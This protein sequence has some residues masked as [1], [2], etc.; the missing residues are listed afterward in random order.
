MLDKAH[1]N[2]QMDESDAY[3]A[4]RTER[5]RLGAL[6]VWCALLVPWFPFALLSG[7]AFDGGPTIQAY[8]FA[9]S[10]WTYPITVGIAAIFRKR[11]PG[12]LM[13]PL[14]NVFCF[15]GSCVPNSR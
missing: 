3:W 13:L 1:R 5:Y 7:M 2:H 12:L 10:V 15:L 11:V 6:I 14:L 4:K 8:L 9:A